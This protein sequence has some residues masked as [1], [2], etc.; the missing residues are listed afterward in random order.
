MI[1][2]YYVRTRSLQEGMT[3]DQNI[4]DRMDRVLIARGTSL[5]AYLIEGL[6]KLGIGGVYIR[7]GEEEPEPE[8][9]KEPQEK[10]V[11][12]LARNN[13]AKYRTPDPS[14]VQLTESVKKRVSEG[15]QYLYN[16]SDSESF[17]D[18]TNSITND[19][20]KAIQDNDAIAVDINALKTS[21]EYTFKHSVDVATM[22][23]IIAK[24]QGLK[25]NEI[26]NIGIAGLLHDMGKAKIPSEILNKPA[27]LS[28]EEFS[29]MKQHSV[30][31][32]NILKEKN[33]FTT[34]ISL[35]VLQHHEKMNGAG[36][37]L[38]VKS[39][40]ISPYAKILSVADVYDALVTERPYK[41]SFSQRTAVEMI[42]SM[43][44][45]LDINAMRSFLN[46]VILYPVDSVVQLSNGEEARV[47]KNNESSV[48]R[49]TVVGL[50][51][52]IVYDLTND[53]N[54]ANII[55]L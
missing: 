22:S 50:T 23:M 36:Y 24:K 41:K 6:Q 2:R 1:K 53:I 51:S 33:D 37:P 44:D 38:G 8:P 7:E 52:G 28:D 3:I 54:C 16:N 5:N 47:V 19:L 25:K 26:Y 20:M 13:I 55:I 34:A 31:G 32:Y 4:K 14:K 46:S 17:A 27:R 35:A 29:I 45:E 21:D 30:L 12:A 11:S 48:L 42:M 39:D 15:I 9:E 49:P 18:T 40:K 10:P 43:T